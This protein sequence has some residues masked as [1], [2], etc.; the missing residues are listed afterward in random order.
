MENTS[1]DDHISKR[2]IF[3]Y[4]QRNKNRIFADICAFYDKEASK[5]GDISR[6]LIA[7]KLRCNPSQITRWLSAPSN[8]TLD[9]I[10]DLLLPLQ[11]EMTYRI[12]RFAD[13][14]KVN[15]IHPFIA[16]LSDETRDN[17]N[18]L[19]FDNETRRP[20]ATSSSPNRSEVKRLE[21]A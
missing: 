12:V 19:A 1:K 8:L 3:Y 21:L 9:T 5:N 17:R 2:D 14:P 7:K 13:R 6:R 18:E 20:P 10:S 15:F 16:E 11:A 4:R